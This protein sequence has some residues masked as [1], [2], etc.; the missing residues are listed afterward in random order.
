[1]HSTSSILFIEPVCISFN[2]RWCFEALGNVLQINV[3]LKIAIMLSPSFSMP[4]YRM[5]SKEHL[6]TLSLYNSVILFFMIDFATKSIQNI[7][8][9]CLDDPPCFYC[10][11]NLWTH[12]YESIQIVHKCK[13]IY[14]FG[15]VDLPS[16]KTECV[17]FIVL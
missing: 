1:M 15:W 2:E 8:L 3:K 6:N 7:N 13:Y 4:H 10:C 12:Q 14:K 9:K 11:S 5:C 17:N 16:I